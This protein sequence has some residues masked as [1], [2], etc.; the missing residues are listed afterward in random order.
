M[1]LLWGPGT[2]LIVLGVVWGIILILKNPEKIGGF[3]G[4]NTARVYYWLKGV[5]EKLMQC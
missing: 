4:H 2:P 3:A 1:S 5:K